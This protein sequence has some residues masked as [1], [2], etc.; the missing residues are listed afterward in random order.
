MQKYNFLRSFTVFAII[1]S[2]AWFAAPVTLSGAG[3]LIIVNTTDL[4]SRVNSESLLAKQIADERR[5][6]E[7]NGDDFLYLDCGDSFQGTFTASKS[8]GAEMNDYFRAAGLDAS[9][10]GN[11]EFDFGI[12]N[13]IRRRGRLDKTAVML[14]ANL[15]VAG[16]DLPAFKIFELANNRV[17][18][19]GLAENQLDRR[20]LPAEGFELY[21]E[22]SALDRAVLEAAKHNPDVI[23][24]L[25]HGGKYGGRTK[26]YDL[27]KKH[28]SINLVFGGHTHEVAE[29]EKIAESFYV[30]SGCYGKGYSRATIKKLPGGQKMIRNIFVELPAEKLPAVKR[31][32]VGRLSSPL[33][34]P[35]VASENAPFPRL[36]AES[37]RDFADADAAIFECGAFNK[38]VG[39]ELTEFDLYLLFPY[40][41]HAA[42]VEV[43]PDE[44]V[45]LIKECRGKLRK[46]KSALG[47]SPA[48]PPKGQKINLAVSGYMLAGGGSR[49]PEFAKLLEKKDRRWRDLKTPMREI[50]RKHVLKSH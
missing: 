29:G 28:P 33:S 31:E 30:Q 8:G 7:K 39:P 36:V 26:L 50:F 25:R 45:N 41:D 47:F 21:E 43:T 10:P 35:E 1:V 46:Y 13:F 49:H 5:Q 42:V 17:A 11:H 12:R 44:Y 23:I 48:T 15:K 19:I 34:A 38:S 2:A 6:A 32:I 37:L 3:D 4:H 20:V 14:G 9:V 24:L 40:E 16:A 27:L 22:V 18:V